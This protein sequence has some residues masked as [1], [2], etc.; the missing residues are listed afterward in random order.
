MTMDDRGRPGG[1]RVTVV[2]ITRDRGVEAQRSVDRLLSLPE[3]PPVIVVDNGSSDRT[4]QLLA[5][6]GERVKVVPLGRNA[7]AA[8]RNVGVAMAS[9]PFVA[10]ADDDSAWAPGALSRGVEILDAHPRLAVVAA[11]V[12]LGE[13]QLLD[14]ACAVMAASRLPADPQLPGRPVLGFVACAALV[15]RDAFIAAGGFDERYGV[16]GE[17]GPLAIEL[18]ARG[19]ALTYVD[20]VIAQ[21]WPSPLRDP[22][23]RRRIVVRN[24]LWLSW[25]R[26]R[27]PTVLRE[28]ARSARVAVNDDAARAGLIDATR[29]IVGVFRGR[30]CVDRQLVRR[31]QLID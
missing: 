31:L 12:L 25:S 30:R 19:W 22:T 1:S 16:G 26:R 8:G 9:T 17:E 6:R 18:A 7:G 24:A 4:V 5:S 14:P 29:E 10:F 11:R 3:R 21:H 27:W 2:M 20:D 28:T 15:R 23:S 13:R